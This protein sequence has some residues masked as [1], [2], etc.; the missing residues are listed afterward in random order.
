MGPPAFWV[1]EGEQ[2]R[3]L[4]SVFAATSAGDMAMLDRCYQPNI[5]AWDKCEVGVHDDVDDLQLRVGWRLRAREEAL[6]KQDLDALKN[7]QAEEMRD[8]D[9]FMQSFDVQRH[10]QL[11][12]PPSLQGPMS[13]GG[14]AGSAM[15]RSASAAAA[16]CKTSNAGPLPSRNV[17]SDDGFA[18]SQWPPLRPPPLAGRVGWELSDELLRARPER[19]VPTAC[20]SPALA[21]IL[22]AAPGGF[23][24]SSAAWPRF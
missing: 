22:A 14:S 2:R 20:W 21:D 24:P 18:F 10:M 4:P 5:F 7:L 1:D 11:A 13:R 23:P 9:E 3:R 19:R 6:E 15:T 17:A 8:A 12:P 16:P